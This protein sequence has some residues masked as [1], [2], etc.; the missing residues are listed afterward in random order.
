MNMT[1][2]DDSQ[3]VD[4]VPSVHSTM[5]NSEVLAQKDENDESD[6]QCDF[7]SSFIGMGSQPKPQVNN[8]VDKGKKLS[9]FSEFNINFQSKFSY[10][11]QSLH[12]F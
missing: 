4:F 9:G 2:V 3:L 11:F 8:D 7:L 10:L 12:N 6:L 5:I 1:C